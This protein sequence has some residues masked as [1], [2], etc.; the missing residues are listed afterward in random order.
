V[1]WH[2]DLSLDW[3]PVGGVSLLLFRCLFLAVAAVVA[4]AAD[5]AIGLRI[6]MMTMDSDDAISSSCG[7]V[8]RMLKT[9]LPLSRQSSPEEETSMAPLW[10][11]VGCG[12]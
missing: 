12:L 8:L 4:A 9:C 11:I 1:M 7:V 5:W 3:F 2:L 10:V 6:V